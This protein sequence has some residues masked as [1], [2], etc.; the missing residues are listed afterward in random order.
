MNYYIKAI[1]YYLPEHVITNDYLAKECDIDR[2]FLSNKIGII[3]RRIAGEKE[4]GSDMAY[5]SA[6]ALITK[7]HINRK[8]IDLLLLCTQNP[9]YNLPTT[10]CI[11]QHKL[12]LPTKCIAFDVN[13]GC[14]GFIYSLI[15]AGN[16]I[17]TGNI[18]TAL[19]IMVD[20]YSKII[21]YKD[22]NT[23]SLFGDASSSILLERMNEEDY[24][25][26][27]YELG[28]DGSGAMN[29]VAY[30]SGL[31]KSEEHSNYLYMD[32]REIFK[33]SINIVPQSV[34]SFIRLINICSKK[35]RK[36]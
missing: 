9:D 7:H 25:I 14:S 19:L 4:S 29:L 26:I 21:D 17:K 2:D 32:G 33:F 27:D 5:N 18:K 28:T 23:A 1:E 8:N 15:I 24:G 11:V 16:F 22:K 34:Q 30:N 35:F 12:K 3:E 31:V 10:A 13:L 6:E 20:Q 36:N